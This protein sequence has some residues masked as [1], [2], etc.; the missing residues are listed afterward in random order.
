MSLF[1]TR[2]QVVSHLHL[3]TSL[4]N[5]IYGKFRLHIEANNLLLLGDIGLAKDEGFSEK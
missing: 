5:P 3:E 1:N 4:Q 2:F